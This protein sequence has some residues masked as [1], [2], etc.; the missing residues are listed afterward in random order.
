MR[1]E[2]RNFQQQTIS[3]KF[4]VLRIPEDFVV[5]LPPNL[6][7]KIKDKMRI[8]R[9]KENHP[10]LFLNFVHLITFE[11]SLSLTSISL[12]GIGFNADILRPLNSEKAPFLKKDNAIQKARTDVLCNEQLQS[13]VFTVT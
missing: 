5:E 3:Q 1:V 10:I 2:N 12:N 9:K 4:Q 8:Y 7:K 6:Y 11:D 13:S